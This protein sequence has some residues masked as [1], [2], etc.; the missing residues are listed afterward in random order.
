MYDMPTP[1]H[2]LLAWNTVGSS[3]SSCTWDAAQT[4]MCAPL[5]KLAASEAKKRIG[6]ASTRLHHSILPPRWPTA[7]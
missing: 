5:M 6:P 4:G 3:S 1:S 7:R 2:F